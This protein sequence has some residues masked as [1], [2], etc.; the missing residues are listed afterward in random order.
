MK[1]TALRY[2]AMLLC[3]L[4]LFALLPVGSRADS[5]Y[6]TV[7]K[8][9]E[10]DE[11]VSLQIPGKTNL[12]T[13]MDKMPRRAE[14]KASWRN[15]SIY[16]MPRPAEANGVLGTVATGTP[17]TILARQ[18]GLYFFM[19]DDGRMGWNGVGFFTKPVSI[20]QDLTAPL[21]DD[22]PLTGQDAVTVSEFLRDSKRAGAASPYFYADR[23]VVIIK[24]GESA[25]ITVRG[26]NSK[27]P[28]KFERTDGTSADGE[29]L[30]SKFSNYQRGVEF[31]A[32]EPG[33]SI[34]TFTNTNNRQSFKILVIVTE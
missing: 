23:P 26:L 8:S 15:G 29:W 32:K 28:Y 16:F 22:S 27:A 12:Y 4:S 3:V 20:D 14:V 34:F 30:G 2:T 5:A 6:T 24:N 11:Y 31:T 18:N 13:E 25:T 17:V 10:K 9:P 1:K 7:T 21:G 33:A 19:T